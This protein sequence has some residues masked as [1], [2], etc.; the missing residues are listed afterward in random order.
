MV[1]QQIH[2]GMYGATQPALALF[3]YG[4]YD[5]NTGNQDYFV[6]RAAGSDATPGNYSD[7]G[8]TGSNNWIDT[9]TNPYVTAHETRPAAGVYWRRV[10]R[11]KPGWLAGDD[12]V[13]QIWR[14][15][16]GQDM[17]NIT[18]GTIYTGINAH[19]NLDQEEFAEYIRKGLYMW[20]P[21]DNVI[22]YNISRLYCEENNTGAS[23]A[24][25]LARGTESVAWAR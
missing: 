16:P 19:N 3:D 20:D 15:K 18:L 24:A 4:Y 23:G 13:I 1:V 22:S 5:S 21:V 8:G 6:W 2:T 11:Y 12:K 9:T 14:G 7:H 25:M 10:V 17:E